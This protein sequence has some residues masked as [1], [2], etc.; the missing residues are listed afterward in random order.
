MMA[1]EGFEVKFASRRVLLSFNEMQR[2]RMPIDKKP[3][4]VPRDQHGYEATLEMNYKGRWIAH[5]NFSIIDKG[6]NR[7]IYVGRV[8][9]ERTRRDLASFERLFSDQTVRDLASHEV[10]KEG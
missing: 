8:F 10:R 7:G 2:L 9:D 1:F 4:S 3:G 5:V 6:E